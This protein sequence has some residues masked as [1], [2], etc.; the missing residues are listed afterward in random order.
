MIISY[1]CVSA[2]SFRPFWMLEE[3][4]VAYELKMMPFPPRALARP[5]LEI[6]PLGTVP[7]LFDGAVFMTES[8]AICQYLAARFSPGNLDV[9]ADE[10]AFGAYLNYLH[11]A[12]ATLTFP[13]TLVLRY[14][15]FETGERRQGARLRQVVPPEVADIGA[16]PVATGVPLC[17]P[18]HRRRCFGR[19]RAAAGAASR[20]RPGVHVVGSRVL[21]APAGAACVPE[22][23]EGSER[24]RHLARGAHDCFARHQARI[25]RPRRC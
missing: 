15:H 17:G 25:T 11:F 24:R 16:S 23:D 5:Y 8:S 3:I 4:G 21:G 13:Q 1:H 10:P 19:V 14:L 18:F 7:V 20:P 2:R 6:N 9:G 22:R 12:E